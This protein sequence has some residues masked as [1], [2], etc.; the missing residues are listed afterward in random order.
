MTWAF[1]G[2]IGLTWVGLG[3]FNWAVWKVIGAVGVLARQCGTYQGRT[4]D[5][6]A[7]L[8]ADNKMISKLLGRKPPIR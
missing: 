4:D 1:W 7:I 3:F 6:L 2:A 8:E 5:R